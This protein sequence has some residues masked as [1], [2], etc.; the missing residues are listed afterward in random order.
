M[1]RQTPR[2]ALSDD[3]SSI[4]VKMSEGNPGAA[5]VL[6]SIVANATAIDPDAG[7]AMAKLLP[8][9]TMDNLDIYGSRIYVL[10]SDICEKHL[11]STIALLRA[12]HLGILPENVLAD[13]C[14]RQDYSGR[15]LVSVVDTCLMVSEALP[16]FN[17]KFDCHL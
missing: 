9:L 5:Q 16:N 8:I 2:I 7:P 14:S 4:V 6:C 3:I 15:S 12:V 11:P 17:M 1:S 10:Y 13:A